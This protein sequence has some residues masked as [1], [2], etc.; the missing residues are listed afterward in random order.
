MRALARAK[1]TVAVVVLS[2]AVGTGANAVLYSAMDAL[3]FR[4]AAGVVK[5][6][7]LVT[8]STSQFN[9]GTGASRPTPISSLCKQAFRRFSRWR[10]SMMGPSRTSNWVTRPARSTGRINRGVFFDTRRD[11]HIL[12]SFRVVTAECRE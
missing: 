8:I 3:L 4:P 2:L 10:R 7:R 9:G 11:L 1:T 6:S 5:G 12:E